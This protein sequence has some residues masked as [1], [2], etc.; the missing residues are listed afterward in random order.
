[1]Y[2]G[3][4]RTNNDI[5]EGVADRYHSVAIINPVRMNNRAEAV[6]HDKLIG[7]MPD[8]ARAIADNE[9]FYAARPDR[10][11]KEHIIYKRHIEAKGY[12][13]YTILLDQDR[14][15][16]TK[17]LS[18]AIAK[19]CD[20]AGAP[21]KYRLVKNSDIVDSAVWSWARAILRTSLRACDTMVLYEGESNTSMQDC[22]KCAHSVVCKHLAMGAARPQCEHI[23]VLNK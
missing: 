2:I 19:I 5:A 14:Q 21:T 9:H 4:S 23:L 10:Y 1:M 12:D 8:V 15:Y 13:V 18:S 7:M 3:F 17:I 20:D 6:V 16:D 22:S 11:H